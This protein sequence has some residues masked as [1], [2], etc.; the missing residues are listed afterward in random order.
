M[1]ITAIGCG[2]GSGFKANI[3]PVTGT[4]TVDGEPA[5]GLL[6]MFEPLG[7]NAA[8]DK[9]T[10]VGKASTGVTDASGKFELSYA[11]GGKG[12]VVG[13]HLVKVMTMMGEG[14]GADPDA[15]PASKYKIPA[16][17]NTESGRLEDVKEGENS[18]TI[19]IKTK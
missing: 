18:I 9:N 14:G 2:G 8:S 15:V 12:A 19:E 13:K 3:A 17:Y 5:E 10:D 7:N 16:R 11:D 4:V 6:V 1:V